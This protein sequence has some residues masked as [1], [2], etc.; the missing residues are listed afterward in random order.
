MALRGEMIKGERARLQVAY[1]NAQRQGWSDRVHWQVDRFCMAAVRELLAWRQEER[2]RLAE[3]LRAELQ[4]RQVLVEAEIAALLGLSELRAEMGGFDQEEALRAT[5]LRRDLEIKAAGGKEPSEVLFGGA[6]G[7]FKQGLVANLDAARLG[8]CLEPR[9][10]SER[11]AVALMLHCEIIDS[12]GEF[13]VGDKPVRAAEVA[14]VLG[15]GELNEVVYAFADKYYQQTQ[16]VLSA[17]GVLARIAGGRISSGL[18]GD[19]D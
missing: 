2:G 14:A 12:D 10:A 8:E 7:E 6:L 15:L 4:E 1:L 17:A 11:A 18:D 9:A 13:F 16:V 5:A 3:I 19:A